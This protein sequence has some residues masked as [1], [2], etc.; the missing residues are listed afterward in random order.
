MTAADRRRQLLERLH[1][2]PVIVGDGAMGTQLHQLGAPPDAVFEY[3]N[4]IDAPLVGRV[5]A[6]YAAA[7]AELLETNTF[8]ANALRLGAYGLEAKVAAINRAG[9]RL[10]REAAGPARFVAGSVGPLL[11]AR[12]GGADPDITTR[13]A[14]FA[15]QMTAL[16]EAGIDCFLLETFPAVADLQLALGIARELDV[17][18]IAQLAFTEGGFTGDGLSAEQAAQ[19]L[20]AAHPA[21]I[22]ANCGAGPRELLLVLRRL[23]AATDL[24]LTAF[25]NS[26]FPERIDGRTFYLATPGYFAAL[27]RE[28]AEA[29]AALIGGCCGTG[30]GHVQALAE[31]LRA[32]RPGSR[33]RPVAVTAAAPPAGPAT[34]A[35]RRFLAPWGSRP[36]VT[37]ELDV[38]K[39]LD[40]TTTVARARQ[41]AEA[42]VD[43]FNLAENPLARI[44]MSNIALAS[45]LQNE[46][47]V[48]AIPHITGRDR[49]L[50]GLHSALMGAHLL[51]IRS[52]LAVTGDPVAIGGEA[53]AGNVFDLNSVGLLKLID[54]LNHGRTLY[55]AE[56]GASAGFVAGCAFNPNVADLSG[57]L[58]KLEKKLA[59]G[60]RF[61]QTQPLFD[62]QL[63][64][65]MMSAVRP[66]GVPVLVGLMPL[67]SERNAEFLHNE[68]PGI[69]LP[70]AV[71]QRMRGTTGSAGV[72]EGMAICRDLLTEGKRLG[73]GG[74]YLIPPFGKVELALELIGAIRG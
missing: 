43:A 31:A 41:L 46:T 11:P 45:R 50:L 15:E 40:V 53:G 68:V 65:R 2:G 9:V 32:R 30:P 51:G 29:G 74:Y 44:R 47:G 71:R 62:P 49:N 4:L 54:A 24:P 38:P 34:P 42:G 67:V 10:A 21:A 6:A 37:V 48:E 33:V 52:V 19:Q 28:M 14:V 36:L 57:Q 8:G 16:A 61:V 3:L 13:R 7:G 20:T 23:A 18:A 39:G 69:V 26:G 58:H 27:G 72:R 12:G 22:G 5:H 70:D 17:P 60:A 59:A 25:P 1:H 55:G 64:E 66:L 73:V 35:E 56:L 63:L